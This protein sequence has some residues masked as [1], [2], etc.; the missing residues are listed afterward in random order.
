[1]GIGE[2]TVIDGA[3]AIERRYPGRV[4]LI[5][6][7]SAAQSPLA[8]LGLANLA[9]DSYRFTFGVK[10]ELDHKRGLVMAVTENFAHFDNGADITFH[11]GWTQR[12]D[13][14]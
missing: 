14:R 9:E 13:R 4:S 8:D 1:M 6:Q 3:T 12:F 10:R 7:I 2:Q 11:F 5:Y